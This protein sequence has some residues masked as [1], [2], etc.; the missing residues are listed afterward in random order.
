NTAIARMME[1]TNFFTRCET[2]PIEAMKT[3]LVLLSPYAPHLAEELWKILGQRG[4]I[5][6]QAWPDWDEAALVQSSIEIPVQFN[7]KVK[8]KIQVAPDAKPDQMIEAALSDDRVQTML[9]GKQLVKRIAVPARL[10]NLVV[11]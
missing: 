8:T 3:F 9:E 10:V 5:A 11:R 6:L 7:G 1:F 2:R 4:S